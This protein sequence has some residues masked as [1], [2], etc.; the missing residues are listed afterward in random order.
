MHL[1][2]RRTYA[3]WN[4]EEIIANQASYCFGPCKA[5]GVWKWKT[6]KYFACFMV[7]FSY[8]NV[9][10]LNTW[11]ELKHQNGE[12]LYMLF[13]VIKSAFICRVYSL[14]ICKT[15]RYRTYADCVCE[16][17]VNVMDRARQLNRTQPVC[18]YLS[19]TFRLFW[20]NFAAI[21]EKEPKP[22]ATN[23][24]RNGNGI[25]CTRSTLAHRTWARWLRLASNA[26]SYA[27]G[28]LNRQKT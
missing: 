15:S 12:H 19:R 13:A 2:T 24:K 16:C 26:H 9:R 17:V 4:R 18:V 11:T 23:E 27:Y 20:H 21:S 6:W 14:I 25:K 22:W 7:D 10:C 1:R 8:H 5:R 28:S 3:N